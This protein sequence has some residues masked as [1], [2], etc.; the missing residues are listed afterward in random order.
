MTNETASSKAA[1]SAAR[2]AGILASYHHDTHGDFE[3]PFVY[4]LTDLLADLMHYCAARNSAEET[5]PDGEG[6]IWSELLE[7]ADMHYEAEQSDA[8]EEAS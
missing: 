7:Q 2:A 8:D 6:F 1:T 4:D 3:P 5:D